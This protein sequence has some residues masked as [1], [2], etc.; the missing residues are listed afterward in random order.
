[1]N[2]T[3]RIDALERLLWDGRV[4]N[5]VAIV[6]CTRTSTGQRLVS[7]VDLGDEDGSYLGDELTATVPTLREAIDRAVTGDTRP[8]REGVTP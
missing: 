6:P 8:D 1:M 7:L 2:D 5:G 3:E 4:G